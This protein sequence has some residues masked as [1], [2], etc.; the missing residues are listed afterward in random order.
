MCPFPSVL[1]RVCGRVR[2]LGGVRAPSLWGLHV[3]DK[4]AERMQAEAAVATAKQRVQAAYKN[5]QDCHVAQ[6]AEARY[7]IDSAE[8]ALASAKKR[9][10]AL[11][12]G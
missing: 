9:L 6:L 2:C 12:T 8:R 1:A 7:E 4:R 5:W 11:G 3:D 10:D